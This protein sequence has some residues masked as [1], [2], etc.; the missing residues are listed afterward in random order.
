MLKSKKQDKNQHNTCKKH[1]E[2]IQELKNEL[3]RALADFQNYQK[4]VEQRKEQEHK[5]VKRDVF[6]DIIMLFENLHIALDNLKPE[7]KEH[8]DIQGIVLILEQYK[9]ILKK[10]G[11]EEISYKPG[12]TPD[13]TATEIIGTEPLPKKSKESS[14][15][16]QNNP[17]DL[18]GKVAKLITPGYKIG[19]I[20]IKQARVIVYG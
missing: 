7:L 2:Q 18:K 16:S 11:V 17:Q 8:P 4:R 6:K 20:I 10:H 9:D 12:D 13:I 1:K 19:D 3:L 5:L 14:S 15:Q